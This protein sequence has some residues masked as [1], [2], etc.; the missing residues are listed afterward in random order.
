MHL[1]FHG[2]RFHFLLTGDTIH[3]S[4]TSF[5]LLKS[6]VEKSR[7]PNNMINAAWDGLC[8]SILVSS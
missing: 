3:S 1:V 2:E 7:S 8:I 5:I 6:S 4:K